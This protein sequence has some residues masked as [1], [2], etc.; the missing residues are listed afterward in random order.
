MQIRAGFGLSS[1]NLEG[2]IFRPSQLKRLYRFIYG[3]GAK[4]KVERYSFGLILEV[5][6]DLCLYV[7]AC[8]WFLAVRVVVL[9]G[10]GNFLKK[11][12]NAFSVKGF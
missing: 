8:F 10:F 3:A 7:V 6:A 12:L 9:S 11:L 2:Y 5:A 4:V 1:Q